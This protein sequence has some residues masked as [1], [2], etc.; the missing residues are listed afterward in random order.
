M[1][2][3]PI[4]ILLLLAAGACAGTPRAE[5][6]SDTMAV[7]TPPHPHGPFSEWRPLFD[8]RT[9]AG[10][11]GYRQA[12]APAGWQVVDGALTRVAEGG[13]LITDEQFDSFELELEWNVA[14]GGNSG[15]FY[16]VVEDSTLSYVWQTGTEMQVL[17]NQRHADGRS[18]HT[19]AGSNFALYPPT[20]DVTRAAGEWNAARLVVSGNH[21]EHWLNGEK[22]VEYELGSPEWQE[23]V[24]ASKFAE[25]PRYA[26]LRRGH[27][28]LQDHGDRV[29]YRNIRIRTPR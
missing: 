20:R 29:S 24:R 1:S 28:A 19:S 9:T 25:M 11:R 21:V 3:R 6:G 18:A 12:A 23:R 16:H 7:V 26:Q 10:W 13:D 8:G 4:H 17:D 27:I 5:S 2:A 14:P 22:I 15:I